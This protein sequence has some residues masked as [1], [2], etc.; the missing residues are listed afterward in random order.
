MTK[1]QKTKMYEEIE[2]HGKNLLVIFPNAIEKDPVKLC[3]KLLRL[4]NKLHWYATE[5]CNGNL[6]GDDMGWNI[7]ASKIVGKVAK[8]LNSKDIDIMTNADCR[9]YSLK[10]N[11]GV[12]RA[13]NL[14]IYR[15]FGGYGIIAPDFTPVHN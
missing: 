14:N 5:Y 8:I 6:N 12:V 7:V 15:D 2:K 1:T 9:G 3:K 4:E 11:A 10:I 13:K